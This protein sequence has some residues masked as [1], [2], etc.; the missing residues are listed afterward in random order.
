MPDNNT[1][2]AILGFAPKVSNL[3]IKYPDV[4]IHKCELLISNTDARQN[5]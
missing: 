3:L 1:F 4:E 2:L 5:K